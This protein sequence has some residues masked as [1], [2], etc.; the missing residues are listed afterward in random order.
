MRKQ[1]LTLCCLVTA[2][3]FCL[4]AEAGDYK[5]AINTGSLGIQQLDALLARAAEIK[6]ISGRIDFLSGQ[7][8][9][10][11]YKDGTLIGDQYTR[12]ELVIDLAGVDCFTFIDYVEAMRRS[13]SFAAFKD[14]LR[15]VR[16]R[17]GVVAYKNRNH[18]FSDWIVHN[19]GFIADVTAQTGAGKARTVS[20]ILNAAEN[21]RQLLPGIAPESRKVCYIPAEAVDDALLHRLQSGDYLGI[22]STRNDLD[23]SHVGIVIRKGAGIFFRHASSQEKY[24][25]VVDQDLK[26]YLLHKPGVVILRPKPDKPE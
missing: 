18:F 16:Y 21:G 14:N 4:R 15:N 12:E 9:G 7:F 22:Y 23:V 24:R 20:K 5:E 11:S 8:T 10:I 25:Q 19:A 6:D 3:F 26:T 1:I 13:G 17:D 2:I